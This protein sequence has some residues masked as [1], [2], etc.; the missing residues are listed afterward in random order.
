MCAGVLPVFMSVWGCQ[1]PWI[2]SYK[3]VWAANWVLE[4]KPTSFEEQSV[5]SPTE[6]SP[7]PPVTKHFLKIIKSYI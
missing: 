7:Q 6:P 4:T 5:F 1:I 2:W 3:Q